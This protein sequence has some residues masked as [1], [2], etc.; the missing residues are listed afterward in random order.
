M[1]FNINLSNTLDVNF[2]V[3]TMDAIYEANNWG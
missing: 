3:K 2:D 1:M